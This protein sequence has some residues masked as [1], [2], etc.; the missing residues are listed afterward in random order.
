MFKAEHAERMNAENDVF[1]KKQQQ[2][3]QIELA[4]AAKEQKNITPEQMYVQQ[5]WSG[6]LSK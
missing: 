2:M 6:G 3:V 5:F 1:M 4:E